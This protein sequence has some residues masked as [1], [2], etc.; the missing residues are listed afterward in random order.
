MP[1][2]GGVGLL[3]ILAFA[4]AFVNGRGSGFSVMDTCKC[5]KGQLDLLGP[6]SVSSSSKLSR[7]K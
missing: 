1:G 2:G 5:A 3:Y 6:P 7:E 4:H